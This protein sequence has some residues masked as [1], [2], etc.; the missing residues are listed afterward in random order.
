[1]ES[2][3]FAVEHSPTLLAIPSLGEGCTQIS[4][5]CPGQQRRAPANSIEIKERISSTRDEKHL[6]K[7]CFCEA[8]EHVVNTANNVLLCDRVKFG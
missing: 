2:V 5:G 8:G 7:T 3:F 1:M 6:G 4:H